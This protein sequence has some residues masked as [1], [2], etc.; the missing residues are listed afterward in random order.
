MRNTGDSITSS[1]V[2]VVQSNVELPVSG[3]ILTLGTYN[4]R[5]TITIHNKN[6]QQCLFFFLDTLQ[7]L[8]H[9]HTH[10]K[11]VKHPQRNIKRLK[12]NKYRMS[13]IC[14]IYAHI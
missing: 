3:W 12:M 10:T 4:K 9:T 14:W 5:Y 6:T 13:D 7:G 2:Q 1:T 8:S 11:Y